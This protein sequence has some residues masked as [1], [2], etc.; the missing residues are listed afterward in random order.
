MPV[1]VYM[2]ASMPDDKSKRGK[3]D[4]DRVN[5]HEPYELR[6]WAGHWGVSEQAVKD[7]VG[8]AGVMAANVEACLKRKGLVK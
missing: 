6:D 1:Y 4:R 8:T 5:I 2:E 7:C 3:P